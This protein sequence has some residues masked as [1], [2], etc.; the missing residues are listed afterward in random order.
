[1]VGPTLA[2]SVDRLAIDLPEWWVALQAGRIP[3]PSA[4]CRRHHWVCRA[5]HFAVPCPQSGVA[6]RSFAK[7]HPPLCRGCA[8]WLD[9]Q[10]E[11]H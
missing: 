3:G 8:M 6:T 11:A 7:P 2:A 1:M 4:S 9:L 10:V 5:R